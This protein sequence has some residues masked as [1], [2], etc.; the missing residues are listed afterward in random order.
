MLILVLQR[1]EYHLH[2]YLL[3]IFSHTGRKIVLK[4]VKN[5]AFIIKV[6][7]KNRGLSELQY[8]YMRTAVVNSSDTI[9]KM[10]FLVQINESCNLSVTKDKSL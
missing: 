7:K 3:S 2:T 5:V 4:L 6:K 10:I 1:I 8:L 9:G